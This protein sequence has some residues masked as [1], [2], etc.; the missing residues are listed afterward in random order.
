MSDLKPCP[1]C[2]GR[3]SFK[4]RSFKASCDRCGAHVPNGAVSSDEAIAAWNIRA[5]P[6]VQPKVKPLVWSDFKEGGCTG[7]PYP[8]QFFITQAHN[9][10]YLC[11]HDTSWHDDLAAAQAHG[12]E[13][14]QIAA[15]EPAV[16]PDAAAIYDALAQGQKPLGAEFQ[17]AIFGDVES[18]YDNNPG[19]EVMPDVSGSA[20]PSHDAAPASLS[21]GGGAGSAR[22]VAVWQPI[23]T[24]PKDGTWFV[25]CLR[26]EGFEIGRFEPTKRTEYV[27][28]EIDGLFRQQERV[29]Y[30]WGGFNNFHHATHWMPIPAPPATQGGA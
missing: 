4:P 8:F 23:E 16:Q 2:G 18:L 7:K 1:F 30:E 29:I 13:A 12:Q 19:K 26:G 10:K 14:Y 15:L 17:A 21:A 24:A 3:A 9:G 11:H 22:L 27:P 28:S 6:A 20:R 25:I 5:L